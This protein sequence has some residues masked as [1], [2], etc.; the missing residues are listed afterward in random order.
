MNLA[1]LAIGEIS[2][3]T[4]ARSLDGALCARRRGAQ[5]DE[6]RRWP[7]GGVV[8]NADDGSLGDPGVADERG[9][10]SAVEIRLPVT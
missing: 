3:A 5:D 6:L 7:T 4:W 9:L 10:T 8:G 2:R 1:G